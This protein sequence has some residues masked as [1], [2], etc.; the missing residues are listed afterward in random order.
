[1]HIAGSEQISKSLM[2]LRRFDYFSNLDRGGHCRRKGLAHL[3]QIIFDDA[4]TIRRIGKAQMPRCRSWAGR[5]DEKSPQL[6]PGASHSIA[7]LLDSLGMALCRPIMHT[8]IREAGR[9]AAR[10]ARYPFMTLQHCRRG[11]YREATQATFPRGPS[12]PAMTTLGIEP[13]AC[14][15]ATGC[16][17]CICSLFASGPM[18]KGSKTDSKRQCSLGYGWMWT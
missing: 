4:I 10:Y 5:V 1:M 12:E 18:L 11:C 7:L 9:Q 15:G 13:F 17:S 16:I 2:L 6:F 14:A 8:V 3:R